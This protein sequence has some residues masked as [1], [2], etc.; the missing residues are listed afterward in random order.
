MFFDIP[1]LFVVLAA[2][3]S[4][5]TFMKIVAICHAGRGPFAVR[6]D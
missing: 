3:M 4:S 5:K 2:S 6:F 1:C